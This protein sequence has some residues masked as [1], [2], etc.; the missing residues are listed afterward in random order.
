MSV[1]PSDAETPDP[2]PAEEAGVGVLLDP[3][4]ARSVPVNTMRRR[5]LIR[6]IIRLFI[7]FYHSKLGLAQFYLIRTKFDLFT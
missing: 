3:Q 1:C 4:D 2:E 6:E 7:E 5:I